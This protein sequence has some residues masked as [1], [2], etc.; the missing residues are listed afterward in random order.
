MRYAID[1]WSIETQKRI[2]LSP[3]PRAACQQVTH[4][5]QVSLAFFSDSAHEQNRSFEFD[6]GRT[7]RL[8][9]GDEGNEAATV[10]SNSGRQQT[11]SF[12]SHRE[13]SSCGE[14]GVEVSTNDNQRR[15]RASFEEPDTVSFFVDRHVRQTELTETFGEIFGALLFGEWRRRDRADANVF[16]GYCGGVGFEKSERLFNLCRVGELSNALR[17]RGFK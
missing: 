7:Q 16:F 11:I 14:D 6:L 10:I 13:I 8:D 12:A 1:A 2:D 17:R 5:A 15:R 9:D 4:T 3:G